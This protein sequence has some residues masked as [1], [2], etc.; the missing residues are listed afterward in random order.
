MCQCGTA[1][2]QVREAGFEVLGGNFIEVEELLRSAAPCA[3]VGAAF[4]VKVRLVPD[5]PIPDVVMIA[6]CPA[7]VVVTDDVLADF[8]PFVKIRRRNG[9]MLT[10]LMLDFL[11]QTVEGFGSCFQRDRD[12]FVCTGKIIGCGIVDIRLKAGKDCADIN[13]EFPAVPTVEG[14]IVVTG[15]GNFCGSIGFGI[16]DILI[17]VVAAVLGTVVD[18]VHAFEVPDRGRQIKEYGLHGGIPL[19]FVIREY[20]SGKGRPDRPPC[21]APAAG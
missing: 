10:N 2:H 8:C 21:Q 13:R 9:V 19:L 4:G 1:D 5:F 14:G 11:S 18:C 3:P 16:V 15:K 17:G 6:V 12:V 20:R 7:L